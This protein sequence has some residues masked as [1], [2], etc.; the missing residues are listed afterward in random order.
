MRLLAPVL[1]SAA[2]IAGPAI[3]Q[4]AKPAPQPAATTR[5]MAK[6]T[7]KTTTTTMRKAAPAGRMV[8]AKLA[9]GKTVTYNCSLAGNATKA[10][11]KR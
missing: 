11:C 3:A 7:R 10:A 1:A 9:N 8:T 5:Q 2:L 4:T 6:V